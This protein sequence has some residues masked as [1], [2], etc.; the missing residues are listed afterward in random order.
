M[1]YRKDGTPYTGE[2]RLSDFAKDFEDMAYRRIGF[3]S[4][5]NGIEISTVW[6][7][8]D[9]GFGNKYRPLIFESMAFHNGRGGDLECWRYATLEEATI[10]HKWM[11]KKYQVFKS[12]DQ[13]VAKPEGD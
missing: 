10:G 5:A 13:I 1:F 6:L 2:T 3:T 4:L 11:V 12:I 7:G 9:H 8:I